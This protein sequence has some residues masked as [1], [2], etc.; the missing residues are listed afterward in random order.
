MRRHLYL[1]VDLSA[2]MQ[3]RPLLTGV[4]RKGMLTMTE[5]QEKFEFVE[6]LPDSSL[7]NPLVWKGQYINVHLNKQNEYVVSMRRTIL[8]TS[9]KPRKFANAV[10]KELINAQKELAIS[11]QSKKIMALYE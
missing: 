4:G 1:C 9:L 6:A 7:R 10:S 3:E 2:N 8:T 5:E 11:P